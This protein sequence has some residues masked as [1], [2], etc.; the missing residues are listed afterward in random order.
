MPLTGANKFGVWYL[1][2]PYFTQQLGVFS[3]SVL[4]A[5]VINEFL[6]HI[7]VRYKF[8]QINLNVHNQPSGGD[9][10]LYPQKN[11]LL[12]LI[13]DYR[14]LASRYSSNTRRNLK[15]SR[16]SNLTIMKGLKP[17]EL[18][19]LFRENK[20]KQVK[21][22]KTPHYSRLQQLMYTA[23]Y[24]GAGE[25]YGV[26][27]SNNVLCAGAFFLKSHQHLTFLFSATNAYARETG[28]MTFLIDTIIRGWASSQIILDF[29]GSNNTQLARFYKGFGAKEVNY[30]RLDF[31]RLKFPL[32]QLANLKTKLKSK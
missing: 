16:A 32:K 13:H 15:K 14:K 21:H 25:I 20:G 4:N 5:S 17:E 10:Q 11:N 6:T 18:V 23:I 8:A 30:Y 19:K 29:E 24:R 1:F 31:N 7:P 9:Y 26:Y 2:Q 12:D 22:W 28:A 27:S 3:K